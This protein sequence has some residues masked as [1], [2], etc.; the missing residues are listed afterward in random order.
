MSEFE[1]SLLRQRAQEA[2]RRKI[3]RGEV[4]WQAPI[5]YVRTDDNAIDLTPD[6]Q[7]QAAIHGVFTKFTEVGSVRQ[8]L[9]WYRQNDLPLPTFSTESGDRKVVW[10]LPA[11][12][13]ILSILTN[14]VYA[15]TFVFGRR[16]TKTT[17]VGGRARKTD[18]H[19]VPREKWEVVIHDH[20]PPYISWEAFVQNQ[21][22]IEANANMRGSMSAGTKGA[23]K[24]GPAL[25]AGLLRCGRCGRKLHVGYS[26]KNGKVPRYGCRGAHLNHGAAWCISVGGLRLDEAVV[27]TV[28]GALES[29]G[30]DAALTAWEQAQRGD[31][32]KQRALRLA[33][34]KARYEAERIHRQYD[35]TEPENRLVAGE[36]ET[37]WNV[38][39]ERLQ[40]LE[41]RLGACR[42]QQ[43][44]LTEH[45]RQRLLELGHDLD[46][47]WRHPAAPVALKKRILRT[48]LTEI[49]V[50]V[51]EDP[52]QTRMKLHWSGGVHT[53]LLVRRNPTGKHRH[54]TDRRVVDLV[55]DLAKVC[56]D[57]AIASVLNRLGYRTGVGNTWTESRVR[58][59]RRHYEIPRV[60]ARAERS[61]LTLDQTADVTG[62]STKFIRRLLKAGILPGH[63]IVPY[64]PWI[65][66]RDGLELPAVQDA[67]QAVREG[68]RTPLSRGDAAETPLFE[69]CHEV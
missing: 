49:V 59:L 28:L 66:P 52:P 67:I 38:A 60:D 36:L 9:L 23:A 53:E 62:V 24:A 21:E 44:L 16:R 17:I 56:E 43:Q 2:L 54:C 37:R 39:L 6:R 34:E 46:Q 4:L 58:T 40:E 14:P 26:G 65:I 69:A 5:G 19:A 68:R 31:D 61:W 25:L 32:E 63:Q 11:Y 3:A 42:E 55:R 13:R 50:D 29:V 10:R 27:Q 22:L 18:G 7:V 33:L 20:H 8:V 15:G 30:V 47:L 35:A 64:A 51:E 41:A 48:V 1:L 57:P 12:K 45:E